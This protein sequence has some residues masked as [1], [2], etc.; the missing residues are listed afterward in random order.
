MQFL[1]IT[2]Q[3]S[4]PPPEMLVP[5]I[6]AMEAW[7][8]QLRASGKAKAM[9][10]FAGTNGGGGLLDVESHEELDEIMSRFPFGPF[11]HVEIIA[12]SSLDAGLANA[13]AFV[14]EMMA[15]MAKP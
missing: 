12:L 10:S 13:R 5:M 6:G 11:S 8:S 7:A 3:S 15:G 14:Q 9:W 1:V 2:R 4:P